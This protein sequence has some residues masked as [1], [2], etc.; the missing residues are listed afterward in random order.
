MIEVDKIASGLNRDEPRRWG[1]L[2]LRLMHGVVCGSRKNDGRGRCRLLSLGVAS[3]KRGAVRRQEV[4]EG[5]KKWK[6]CNRSA[7][8][9]KILPRI[10]V[11]SCWQALITANEFGCKFVQRRK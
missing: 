4:E 10:G 6:V 7:P 9:E 5:E 11:S 8:R 1:F 2:W 3:K